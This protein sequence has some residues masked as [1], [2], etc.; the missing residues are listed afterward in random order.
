MA[1]ET[2]RFLTDDMRILGDT[3]RSSLPSVKL[4]DFCENTQA[5]QARL[6]QWLTPYRKRYEEKEV[7]V[8]FG[9]V[10]LLRNP[11]PYFKKQRRRK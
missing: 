8:L 11:E 5:L 4:D 9:I 10:G 7:M 2:E 1:I 6:F 3:L